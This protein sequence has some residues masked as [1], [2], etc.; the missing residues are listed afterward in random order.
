MSQAFTDV[1][2]GEDAFTVDISNFTSSLMSGL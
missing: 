1:E 2:A